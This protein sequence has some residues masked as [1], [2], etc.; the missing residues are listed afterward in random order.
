MDD[1]E[2][3]R[4]LGRELEHEPP[5]TLARQR[6][7][8]LDGARRRRR[9]LGR[10]TLLGVV[11]A[12]TAAAIVVPA[13]VVHGRDARPVAPGTT[14]PTAAPGRAMN[15]LL[16]GSDERGDSYSARSDTMMLLHV[17]A[18]RKDVRA[19]SIP[20]DLLVVLPACKTSEG[21]VIPSRRGLINSAFPVGGVSCAVKTVES[22]TGVRIDQTVVVGFTGFVRMVEALGGVRMTVPRPGVDPRSGLRLRP[23][24]QRLDGKEA[25]I[26]VRSRIGYGD[27]S[28]LARIE[29]QQAFMAA[30]AREVKELRG[31]PLRFG[32]FLAVLAASV[33]TVPRLGAGDLVTLARGFGAGASIRFA[34]VP[35]RPARADPNR[36]AWDE[37]GAARVFAPFK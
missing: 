12:V 30:F 23:G 13:L 31:D 11:A 6:T 20:R 24:E 9:V 29:R 34:T 35:V 14:A 33:E 5:P 28:D 15:V 27:G 22:L 7:R 37:D 32:K 8:L 1:L 36:L 17:P 10:W 4:D 25:L 19:V 18:D 26:Y 16:L 21:K 3:I 2:L